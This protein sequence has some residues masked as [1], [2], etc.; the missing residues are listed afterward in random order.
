MFQKLT[1]IVLALILCLTQ[2]CQSSAERHSKDIQ[3]TGYAIENVQKTDSGANSHSDSSSDQDSSTDSATTASF[4]GSSATVEGDLALL[5]NSA[6][7]VS[8]G[9]FWT[10]TLVVGSPLLLLGFPIYLLS[11]SEA[12]YLPGL[13]VGKVVGGVVVAPFYVVEK[14]YVNTRKS[15][16]E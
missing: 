3:G 16:E 5:G 10:S 12:A 8:N 11:E 6:T 13:T 4:D 9:I 1:V 14:S 7:P 15:F 2:G